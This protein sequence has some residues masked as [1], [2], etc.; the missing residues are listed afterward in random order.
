M[1]THRRKLI[2]AAATGALLLAGFAAGGVL[3][4]AF[5]ADGR[6][7]AAFAL[8]PERP[9]GRTAGVGPERTVTLITGDRVVVAGPAARVEPGPGRSGIRF[10]TRTVDGHTQVVPSDALPLL[11]AGRLDER[12]FDVTA[13]VE[14]GYDDRRADLPLLI[15]H[16]GATTGARVT[17]ELPALNARAV[18]ATRDATLW[19]SL[20]GAAGTK[21]WLDG[22]RRPRLDVSVPQVGAPAAWQAG[23]DGTGVTVAVLDSGVD[24]T[25]PDLVGRVVAARNFTDGAADDRDT[26]GHGTHVASTIAGSGAA[27]GGRY[28]GVAPGARL[29]DGKVCFDGK[30]PE[31]AVIAGMQWAAEQGAAVVNLSLGSDDAPGDDPVETAVETLTRQRGVL[32]VAAAG[33]EGVDRSV[34]SPASADSALAVGAVDAADRVAGFSSRGP[35]RGDG[36]LKPD[37]TAPGVAITA[38]RGKDAPFG[39]AGQPYADLDGTSMATPHVAGAAA[40]LRGRRPDWSPARVKAGLMGTAQP[41]AGVGVFAQGAGRVDVGRAVAATV[42]AE[43]ASVSLGFQA[44]PHGD[45]APDAR[46]VT[47]RNA[48]AAPVRL[49]LT[50]QTHGPGGGAAPA[51]MFRLGSDAVDVPAGGQASVTLTADTR[52]GAVDGQFGG[53]VVATAGDSVLRTPFGVEREVESYD[54]TLVHTGRDGA[55]A[56]DGFWSTSLARTD[57]SGYATPYD[58]SGTVTVRLPRG[59]YTLVSTVF[60]DDGAT[61]VMLA[62]PRV[63]LTA[64][65]TIQ[66]DARLARP[67]GVGIARADATLVSAEIQASVEN[68]P[69]IQ[70]PGTTFDG[71]YSGQLGPAGATGGFWAKVA[72]TWAKPDA[73]GSLL[74]SPYVYHATY[75]AAGRMFD[76]LAKRTTAFATVRARHAATVAGS[77]GLKSAYPQPAGGEVGEA[78][79]SVP[80]RLPSTR[81]EHYNT[82]GGA[83]WWSQFSE[84]RLD[85]EGQ[86]GE[87]VGQSWSPLRTFAAGSTRQEDWN[88]AVFGPAFG[89]PAHAYEFVHR[90]GDDIVVLPALFGDGAG[91]GGFAALA[92]GRVTLSRDG[93][94]LADQRNLGDPVQIAAPAAAGR[95]RLEVTGA[96]TAG[97]E[98]STAVGA[99]WTFRSG[100][101]TGD[102]PVRLPLLTVTFA[103]AVDDAQRMPAGRRVSVPVAVTGQPGSETGRIGRPTV[104]VSFDDGRTWRPAPVV[105]AGGGLA[106]QITHPAGTG[107]VSLR[108]TAADDRGNTVEQTIVRAYRIG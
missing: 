22:L 80:M 15:V 54:L 87:F 59:D 51:G 34:G 14:F 67:V 7:P 4:S 94:P 81:D 52:V 97:A 57:A 21:V 78:A 55:P 58:P 92:D 74:D 77:V 17:R 56:A 91:H 60:E 11:H 48:G 44:W 86:P 28:R 6:R 101:V 1:L 64:A 5:A 62:Q 31:S 79:F 10:L 106:A 29:L 40:I 89:Q 72:G 16:S 37:L 84:W 8:G 108:A 66:V 38:A 88:R 100:H 41:T 23:Y 75:F 53:W 90:V 65:Q 20:A 3:P 93:A 26:D 36:G 45:D 98:V 107:F 73:D 85:G 2:A 76:G 102:R 61:A 95:F 27:S 46:T 69:S 68:G 18:R 96:R 24:A 19:K 35:R 13:L 32:F 25:H 99:V 103:P 49:A 42:T 47:Y 30:C 82:D 39:D 70:V 43:P 83:R 63:R 33:N 105:D 71:L 12:L 9:A 104:E 50:T